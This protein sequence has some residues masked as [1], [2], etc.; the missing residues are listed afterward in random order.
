MS[1]MNE[2]GF[3][4][5]EVLVAAGLMGG[6][7]LL[8]M[9]INSNAI[10]QQRMLMQKMITETTL[11]DIYT[12]VND[13]LSCQLTFEGTTLFPPGEPVDLKGPQGKIR[14]FSGTKSTQ[15][16]KLGN[17]VLLKSI[18]LSH[19]DDRTLKPGAVEQLQLELVFERDR[20]NQQN[21]EILKKVKFYV[22]TYG[23][24]SPRA[25]SISSCYSPGSFSMLAVKKAF[26]EMDLY[27]K[28][29]PVYGCKIGALK[30]EPSDMPF[31]CTT[32]KWGSFY[33]D[34]MNQNLKHCASDGWQ[35]SFKKPNNLQAAGNI[36][37]LQGNPMDALLPNVKIPETSNAKQTPEEQ[38]NQ[39]IKAL[40]GLVE[41]LKDQIPCP[42]GVERYRGMPLC[43]P[44]T[45]PKAASKLGCCKNSQGKQTCFMQ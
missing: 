19:P 25:R 40:E 6:V 12:I 22:Q 45:H 36:M 14:Y 13:P 31:P 33:F 15:Q 39:D 10:S 11:S 44:A 42:K 4:L 28:Y 37:P 23:P 27:G 7:A 17:G 26:C 34:R 43:C 30:V 18:Y 2:K 32:D 38:T 16:N 8:S 29:D 41:Q 20:P 35:D 5:M 3:T 24:D 1:I 9:R 21:M